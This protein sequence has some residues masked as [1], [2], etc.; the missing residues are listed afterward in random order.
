MIGRC[1]GACFEIVAAG[2]RRRTILRLCTQ[3]PSSGIG[4]GG[5]WP[6]KNALK[7]P[8]LVKELTALMQSYVDRGRSTPGKPQKN[9]G[10]IDIYQ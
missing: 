10:V 4:G 9:N 3:H 8:D 6:F 2:V 5:A 1:V 7:H